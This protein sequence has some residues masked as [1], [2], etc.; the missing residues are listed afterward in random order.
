MVTKERDRG[1]DME[2]EDQADNEYCWNN[3]EERRICGEYERDGWSFGFIL[4]QRRFLRIALSSGAKAKLL[5]VTSF[6]T[7]CHDM[8]PCYTFVIEVDDA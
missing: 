2:V 8:H 1:V 7:A 3:R 4:A 6:V 5:V